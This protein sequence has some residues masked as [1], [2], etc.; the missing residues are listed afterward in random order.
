MSTM[1]TL[2]SV[3]NLVAV[4]QAAK[5]FLSGIAPFAVGLALIVLLAGATWWD[6]RRRERESASPTP[7]EQPHPPPRQT[8]IEE[9][10][11]H[12][13]TDFPPDRRLFPYELRGHGNEAYPPEEPP[14]EQREEEPP[15]ASGEASGTAPGAASGTASGTAQNG[16]DERGRAAPR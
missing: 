11:P 15:P 14:P 16:P 13:H 6:R 7:Q 5:G 3:E 8:H 2:S 12:A 10:G 4:E 9:P 1:S